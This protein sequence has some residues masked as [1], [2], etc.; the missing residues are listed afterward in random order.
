MGR[1]AGGEVTGCADPACLT[2][3]L[4]LPKSL[5]LPPS[6][7]L[8]HS[9]SL[10]LPHSRHCP[11][12]IPALERVLSL[13]GADVKAWYAAMPRSV[14][15]LPQKR[16]AAALGLPSEGPHHPLYNQGVIDQYY[17]SR[18]CAV[19]DEL[20][21]PAQPLCGA[22]RADPRGSLA[23]L[24]ARMARLER[25]HMHMARLCLHC[26]GG[27]GP[28]AP[29]A[30]VPAPQLPAGPQTPAAATP[31]SWEEAVAGGAAD[32]GSATCVS[33]ASVGGGG[34]VCDS[35]DCGAY[36]ERRKC[37]SELAAISALTHLACQ[38]W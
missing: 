5:P 27:G 32:G 11:Q 37:A 21:L 19:C 20:T 33:A 17:L 15:M 2:A 22:C 14:R 12:I 29:A 23:T 8:T 25:Q 10:F 4:P 26:G 18:H 31:A 24:M 34:I 6:P 16:P 3:T 1:G 36:F 9:L 38:G 35:L 30:S 7:F 28:G 13:V